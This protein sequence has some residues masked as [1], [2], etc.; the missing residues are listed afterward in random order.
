ME[1]NKNNI[2]DSFIEAKKNKH[3]VILKDY[4]KIKTDWQ[5]ILNYVYEQ[6]SVDNDES[7]EKEK[8]A[9]HIGSRFYGNLLVIDPL[10]IA[11]QTGEIWQG[12][13]ELKDFLV[14]INQDSGSDESFEDCKFYKHWHIRPCTCES[15]WH[16][17]GFRISLSNRFVSA[18]N[19]P[20]DAVYLQIVGKSFWKI[21]GSDTQEYELNEGDLLFFPKETSHEVW[22]EGPR[23]GILVGDIRERLS[24]NG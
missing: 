9:R 16:S 3:A 12:I 23:V 6:S 19:D 14:K 17:E 10:W 1:S 15:I 2:L 13:P 18:H 21:V 7:H 4:F 8:E 22:S 5:E 20:W 24:N 11:P